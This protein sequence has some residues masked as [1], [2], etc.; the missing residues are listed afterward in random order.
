MV[1]K[2]ERGASI[3]ALKVYR[4]NPNK[5]IHTMTAR[6]SNIISI[7]AL[8]GKPM[9]IEQIRDAYVAR[10]FRNMM[11]NIRLQHIEMMLQ[12]A[13]AARY[14]RR[15]NSN[16]LNGMELAMKTPGIMGLEDMR[17][18]QITLGVMYRIAY[19]NKKRVTLLI[20]RETIA[21]V[22]TSIEA[23]YKNLLSSRP[24]G[25]ARAG[26]GYYIDV[27]LYSA[28]QENRERIRKVVLDD[29]FEEKYADKLL[30]YGLENEATEAMLNH[31]MKG[32]GTHV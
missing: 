30:F 19:P 12:T 10:V 17:Q 18:M 29:P 7:L 16:L 4:E 14:S 15:A 22:I 2:E 3:D 25:D 13:E 20:G 5:L 21:A 28:W 27:D 26:K 24:M 9:T 6:E 23:F 11:L 31:L 1:E 32:L 8:Y